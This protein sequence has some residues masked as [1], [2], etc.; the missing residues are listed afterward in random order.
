MVNADNVSWPEGAT[1]Q[2]VKKRVVPL[3]LNSTWAPCG[4]VLSV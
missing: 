4:H 1:E 2:A 3:G